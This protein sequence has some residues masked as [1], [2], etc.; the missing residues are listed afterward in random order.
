[1]KDPTDRRIETM[2]KRSGEA[3]SLALRPIT[4]SIC[5]AHGLQHWL[6]KLLGHLEDGTP[7]LQLLGSLP[8]LLKAA[9]F[10]ADSAEESLR[11]L[12]RT[13]V[14]EN[15]ARTALWLK[16]WA[17]D[18]PSK[19]RLCGLPF[20]GNLLF[21]PDLDK[22]LER[23]A[24]KK[25]GFPERLRPSSSRKSFRVSRSQTSARGS[26]FKGRWPA[27]R[28]RSKDNILFSSTRSTPS[29]SANTQ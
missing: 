4:A 18:V 7:V 5:V 16:T 14:L 9:A 20:Q 3:S 23:S 13:V 19:L 26:S 12:A 24:D 15:S 29:T 22:V 25:K 17:G 2:L 11:I 1:M 10:L 27:R 21:G 8:I 6:K 28:G